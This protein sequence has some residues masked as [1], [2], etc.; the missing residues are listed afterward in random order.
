MPFFI[1]KETID[2]VMSKARQIGY[3]EG[4][5]DG[6]KFGER[7]AYAQCLE[8]GH[9][10]RVSFEVELNQPQLLPRPV[11][12]LMLIDQ[13]QSVLRD[14]KS[15]WERAEQ[16]LAAHLREYNPET[17]KALSAELKHSQK[18]VEGLEDELA[19]AHRQF[20]SAQ[21]YRRGL[22]K[23]IR[24]LERV[25]AGLQNTLDRANKQGK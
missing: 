12:I 8:I 20:D 5:S 25:I 10:F 19:N 21:Q 11:N 1:S 18:V 16:K 3:Q 6:Q 9:R 4:Y 14:A 7:S 17:W 22:E 15:R 13:L 2:E 24:D 23:K